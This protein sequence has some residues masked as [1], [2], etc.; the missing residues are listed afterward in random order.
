MPDLPS[1]TERALTQ[2][3]EDIAQLRR[4]DGPRPKPHKLVMLLSVVELADRGLVPPNRIYYDATL[5]TIFENYFIL[6]AD[7]HDWCQ[8]GLPYFHLRTAPFWSLKA[9]Q[10]MEAHLAQLKKVGGG[11]QRILEHIEYAYLADYALG[12]VVDTDARRELRHYLSILINP[13]ANK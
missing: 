2:L 12:V 5:K 10:G 3:K 7:D 6:I 9:K 4:G 8:P 11:D 1:I 13:L